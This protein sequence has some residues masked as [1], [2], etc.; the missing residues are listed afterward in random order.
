MFSHFE[1]HVAGPARRDIVAIL[2]WSRREFGEAAAERYAALI[3]QALTD[4]SN[5]PER[6]G[7]MERREIMIEGAR[8]YHL[9]FSR[10]NVKGQSV[11]AP[12]HFILYRRAGERVIEVGR[13]LH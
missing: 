4:L 7:S 13:I 6:P 5:D 10:S 1:V 9:E 8:T 3:V 12:R 2:K 11:K